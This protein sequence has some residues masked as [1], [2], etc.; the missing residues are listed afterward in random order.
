MDRLTSEIL[1]LYDAVGAGDALWELDL[2]LE[3]LGLL[4]VCRDDPPGLLCAFDHERVP[5]GML[6]R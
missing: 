6:I 3:D 2:P 1:P 5:E 4:A